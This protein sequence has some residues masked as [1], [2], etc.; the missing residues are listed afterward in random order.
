M[1]SRPNPYLTF[2]RRGVLD[3]PAGCTTTVSDVPPGT[4][5]QPGGNVTVSLSGDDV[6]ELRG[7]FAGLA[8]GGTVTAPLEEQVRG[9]EHG[10]RTDRFGTDGL[11]DIAV[12]SGSWL[13]RRGGVSDGRWGRSGASGRR[14]ASP[15]R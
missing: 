10:S 9:D 13:R 14:R 15:R 3:S 12:A 5:V 6:G 2:A 11:V 4:A 8:E 1:A 7:C